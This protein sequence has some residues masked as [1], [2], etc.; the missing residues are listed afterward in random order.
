[1][2]GRFVGLAMHR[3]FMLLVFPN[4]TPQVAGNKTKKFS[5]IRLLN[6]Q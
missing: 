2:P 5:F 4:L 1:M 3:L 6:F